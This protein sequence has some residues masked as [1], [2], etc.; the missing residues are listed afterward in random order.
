MEVE[1][2]AISKGLESPPNPNVTEVAMGAG[3]RTT[4]KAAEAT[5][6]PYRDP[7][8]ALCGNAWRDWAEVSRRHSSQ[9]PT[10][11]GGTG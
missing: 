5:T 2:R 4:A 6:G 10:V 3:L 11:I 1:L 7:A 8:S 9:M